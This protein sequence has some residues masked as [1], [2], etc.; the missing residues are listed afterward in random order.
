MGLRTVE[1]KKLARDK[2]DKKEHGDQKRSGGCLSQGGHVSVRLKRQCNIQLRYEIHRQL[3]KRRLGKSEWGLILLSQK[4]KT[5]PQS[6][7]RREKSIPHQGQPVGGGSQGGQKREGPEKA[8]T[9]LQPI[10]TT[11]S[12]GILLRKGFGRGKKT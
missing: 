2:N 4:K 11:K 8:R 3:V 12:T 6:N 1:T 10:Y 7:S 5:G 9:P